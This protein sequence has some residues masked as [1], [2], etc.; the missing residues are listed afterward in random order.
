MQATSVQLN[1]AP[2]GAVSAIGAPVIVGVAGNVE[3][4]VRVVR[5]EVVGGRVVV[6]RVER[7]VVVF[8]VAVVPVL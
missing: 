4:V 2:L 6:L 8:N 7:V 5:A 1:A 3:R